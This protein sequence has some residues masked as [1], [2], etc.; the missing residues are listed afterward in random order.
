MTSQDI[1]LVDNFVAA[2]SATGVIWGLHCD[3]GWVICDSAIYEET[4][5]MPFW[6]S[7]EAAALHC[8]DQWADFEPVAITLDEF[9]ER[10]LVD[11]ADDAVMLGPDWGADLSGEE[12]EPS[13]LIKKYRV[14]S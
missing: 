8:I 14:V 13:D 3:D 4:D 5:V 2:S 7:Q 10:W 6:S 12:V 9:V 1:S 11:L